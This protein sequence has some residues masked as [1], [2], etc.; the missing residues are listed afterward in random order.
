MVY[1]VDH[2]HHV[3]PLA[4]QVVRRHLADLQ[5]TGTSD[6]V[7][8]IGRV[9]Q[10]AINELEDAV[11]ALEVALIDA[12]DGLTPGAPV[13]HRQQVAR[14][15]EG[16]VQRVQQARAALL[17]RLRDARAALEKIDPSAP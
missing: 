10:D 4:V 1:F 14:E 5:D 17:F 11:V 3:D 13:E 12:R 7:A 16:E 8:E 6:G 2:S 9:V 15:V